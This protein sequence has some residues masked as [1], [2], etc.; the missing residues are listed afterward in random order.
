MIECED[1]SKKYNGDFWAVDGVSLNVQ[2][3]QIVK[4]HTL[5]EAAGDT[6]HLFYIKA[7]ET[8]PE[9]QRAKT[10][11]HATS[12]DLVH[13][14]HHPM[15]VPIERQWEAWLGALPTLPLPRA[16]NYRRWWNN[17][18]PVLEGESQ[19]RA[20]DWTPAEQARLQTLVNRAHDAGLWIR[21]YTLNG[22]DDL[23]DLGWSK[24][25]NFGSLDAVRSRWRAAIAAGVDFVATDQ[26]EAFAG[27]LR[28]R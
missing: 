1:L 16:S 3:G 18:W 20:T 19:P 4:D 12:T 25:Y 24:G 13:W 23:G 17:P 28:G 27:E 14:T 26:Y 6:F 2:P 7:D 22:H 5:V 8:L 10:L 15:A 9:A 11:G 21:F